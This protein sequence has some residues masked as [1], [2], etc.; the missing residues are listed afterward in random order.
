MIVNPASVALAFKGFKTIFTD[1]LLEAPTNA[2]KI[3]MTVPSSSQSEDYGWLG[4]FPAMR[5]WIGPRQ[6]KNL[7]ASGFTIKNRKFESTIEVGRE[8]I[9]DDRL[10]LFKPMFAEMGQATRRHPEEL[11]FGLLASGF[12][13]NCYDGQFFFDTDH[14][15]T[16]AV[17]R[18]RSCITPRPAKSCA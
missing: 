11:I 18:R 13:T 9:A 15:V 6:V 12:A 3:A 16:D 17:C 2:D 5:E 10:G 8:D 14:P 4:Q 7:S 1:A